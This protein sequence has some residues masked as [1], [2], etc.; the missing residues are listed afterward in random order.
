MWIVADLVVIG[1]YLLSVIYFKSK[2]FLRASETLIS[3]VLSFCLVPVFLTPFE[4]FV[5]G[6]ELG[7]EINRKVLKSVEEN[8]YEDNFAL[9]DSL[10]QSF[11]GVEEIKEV[12]EKNIAENISRVII[13][14]ISFV[15]L[16]IVIKFGIFILFIIL[17]LCCKIKIFGFVNKTLGVALGIINATIIIYVA[18]ALAVAVVP[19]ENAAEFKDIVAKTLLTQFFY[20][21]NII[22]NLFL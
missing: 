6:S 21:N 2:G 10:A 1:I 20:N 13:K 15:L 4:K 7:A 19:V 3:L 5:S 14:V 18:C 9:P 12:A 22:L 11:G 17:D 16:F 8:D